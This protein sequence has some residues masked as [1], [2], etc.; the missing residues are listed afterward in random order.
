ML[1]SGEMKPWCV[2]YKQDLGSK[3]EYCTL[4]FNPAAS[5]TCDNLFR[6]EDSDNAKFGCDKG[7]FPALMSSFE[8]LLPKILALFI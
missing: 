7:K 8:P 6:L 1:G 5:V 2:E 3:T 4:G